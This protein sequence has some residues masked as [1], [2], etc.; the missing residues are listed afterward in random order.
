[1]ENISAACC[2]YCP[3]GSGAYLP[4]LAATRDG[5]FRASWA[6]GRC[7][8]YETDL[9]YREWVPG[10]GWD[11]QPIV[12]VAYNSGLSYYNSIA[13]DDAG[14]SHI[15]WADDTSSPIDYYRTFYVHGRGTQFSPIAIPFDQ[16]AGGAWT[17]E[18]SADYGG[19]ALQVAFSSN[20][21]DPDKENYYSYTEVGGQPTAT[22]TLVVPPCANQPFKDVCP[23]DY[24]YAPVMALS[25]QGIIN[26]YTTSPPCPN[27]LWVPC[28][29]PYNTATRAQMAKIISLAANLPNGGQ[30]QAFT[31]VP[32]TNTFFPFVQSAFAAGVIQGYPCGQN[33]FEPCDAQNR[34]YFRPGNVVTRG[35][36]S[37]MV[38]TA[39]GFNEPVSNTVQ[40]FQDVAPGSTFHIYIERMFARGI[41]NGY[42]CGSPGET[43]VPPQNRPYFRP[44]AFVTRGQTAKIVYESMQQ[45]AATATSTSEPTTTPEPEATATAEGTATATA[46]VTATATLE[47]TIEP[48]FTATTE[49]TATPT[50]TSGADR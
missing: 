8:G 50:L 1:V 4:S 43:C 39:F 31:D 12:R 37:K 17:R 2:D 3:G 49:P 35:Q 44:N 9:Y 18:V 20:K 46:E 6:D 25:Q 34:P 11:N 29:L 45:A 16:W 36:T 22:P 13:V 48:T 14:D 24:F 26:G 10:T 7:A 23:P 47:P 32:P 41:I 33:Q 40:S 5:G 27:S 30:T 19:G 15:V 42:P 21:G 38:V 28:F